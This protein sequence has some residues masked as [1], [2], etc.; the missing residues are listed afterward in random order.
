MVHRLSSTGN[1]VD[2]Y[3][4]PFPHPTGLSW[5]E[6]SL[7]ITSEN[8]SI[9]AE[10][11]PTTGQ[12]HQWIRFGTPIHGAVAHRT[13]LWAMDP[14]NNQI[15]KIH[16][17][18]VSFTGG[19]IMGE[20]PHPVQF[21]PRDLPLDQGNASFVWSF[22]DGFTDT[23]PEPSH[24]YQHDGNYTVSLTVITE[25]GTYFGQKP[26]YITVTDKDPTA[27]FRI[28]P[29]MKR[30]GPPP[31]TVTFNDISK[32]HDGVIYSLWDFGDG[33]G[34]SDENPTHTYLTP[35]VYNISLFVK[36]ADGDT[37]QTSRHGL[38][39]V[40]QSWLLPAFISLISLILKRNRD[41]K[42]EIAAICNF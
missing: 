32:S 22:G 17:W 34:S 39:I 5:Q 33:H 13:H 9:V 42:D 6:D 19:Y 21:R 7:W 24:T 26:G 20:E 37:D 31:F 40:P 23:V 35:G 16:L 12:V 29:G 2:S 1:I 14:E 18:R 4:S 25:N 10:V 11:N 3:A 36:E 8:P 28:H 30:E 15:G 38:V 27:S 41:K